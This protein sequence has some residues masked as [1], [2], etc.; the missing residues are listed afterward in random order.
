LFERLKILLINKNKKGLFIITFFILSTMVLETLG[1]GIL[2][3]LIQFFVE[4]KTDISFLNKFNFL[5]QSISKELFLLYGLV[6][7]L[8]FYLLKLLFVLKSIN[9]QNKFIFKISANISNLLYEKIIR[10]DFE[11]SISTE[12]SNIVKKFQNDI[13]HLNVFLLGVL[14]L[15][16]ESIVIIAIVTFLVY[17]EPYGTTSLLI[18]ITLFGVFFQKITS[19]RLKSLAIK[20]ISFEKGISKLVIESLNGLTEIE[21]GN[22][23]DFFLKKMK[24]FNKVKLL[25]NTNITFL[26]Q[27]PRFIFEFLMILVIVVF[28]I[29]LEK[30]Y[31]NTT[32]ILTI[33]GIYTAA[34]IRLLPSLNKVIQSTQNLIFY[35][36][37]INVIYEELYSSKTNPKDYITQIN[38]KKKVEFKNIKFSYGSKKLVFD[39]FN[40][41]IKKGD[42]IGIY[43]KSG[44]G[45][46]TFLNLFTGLVYPSNGE[47]YIDSKKIE[48]LR[49]NSWHNQIGFVTQNTF[50][51]NDTIKKNIAFGV[52]DS[53]INLSLLEKAINDADLKDL[54]KERGL[55]YVIKEN[56]IG[57]SGGQK[58]RVSIARA[59]YKNPKILIFDEATSSLDNASENFIIQT[60]EKLKKD[61]TIII[62]SHKLSNLEICDKVY[63]MNKNGILSK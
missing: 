11:N 58:Q 32:E 36:N 47:I 28:I 38:F 33:L 29:V 51:I 59:L 5:T 57:L 46:S 1:I 3:P 8:V 26:N 49:N 23:H 48:N 56:G 9:Y 31:S 6:G 24:N 14:T 27:S 20:R 13:N 21:V 60:I 39:N 12:V 18:L 30:R 52:D 7:I 40:F 50:L 61:K 42:L 54:I 44:S 25:V 22:F 45:K 55:E 53:R 34:T 10:D 62:V 37:S 16:A 43:G 2:Y 17:I 63:Q 19:S 35:K 4:G 15:T 41:E